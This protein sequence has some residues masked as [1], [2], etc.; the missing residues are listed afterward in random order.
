MDGRQRGGQ[1]QFR[2]P[3]TADMAPNV[4][5]NVTLLQPHAQTVNDLPIRMY[6]VIPILVEDPKT[7]LYPVHKM[8]S[9]LRPE[10]KVTIAVNESKGQEMT[11]TLA[12]VDEG[13]LDITR[14][15]TPDLWNYFYSRE[16]LGVTTWDMYDLVMGAWGAKLERVLSIGGDEGLNKPKEK[17]KKANRFKP[18]VKFMGPFHLKKG[19]TRTH[20]F[21]MPQYIG[22]VRTMVIAG[23]NGAYG[24]AE[25]ATPVRNLIMVLGT[26]PRVLGPD[27]TVALPVSV[28]AMEK[29]IKAVNVQILVN[30][31]LEIVGKIKTNKIYTAWR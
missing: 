1:T 23:E 13:L 15:K 5:I 19:E 30:D 12:V 28:F 16:A 20:T 29:N 18:V 10:E 26:L 4:Y 2:V 31:M 3:V 24:Y 7:H 21:M 9:I 14:F 8:A 25:K 22:S 6:G 11:Y 27:E 17:E